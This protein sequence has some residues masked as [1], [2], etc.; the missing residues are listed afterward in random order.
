M[1]KTDEC[2]VETFGNLF[3]HSG[4]E[5]IVILGDRWWPQTAEKEGGKLSKTLNLWGKT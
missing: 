2:D 4:E 5:T 1:R 3:I